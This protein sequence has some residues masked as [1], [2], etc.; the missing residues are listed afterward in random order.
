MVAIKLLNLQNEGAQKSFDREC[1]VLGRV[2]HWNL[3][4]II[5]CYSDLQIKALIFPLMSNGSLEKWLYPDDG[6]QSGLNLI[7]RL[8]IAIDIAQGMAYLHHHCFVQVI[9]CD[10][11]PNNVLLGEDITAYLIDFGI[12]TI[13]FAN[14]ED[15]DFTSTN[16]LKGSTGYIAPEYGVGGQVTTKGDVY[17]YGIMLLEMLTRKKPTNDMFAE[18]MN[19]QKWVGSLFPSRVQEV[20]DMS[21]LRRTNRCTEEDKDL[22]CLSSLINVGLL[23]TNESPQGRPTM[24][25]ILGTLQNIRDTFLSSTSIPKFQSNLTHLLGS[26]S[27]TINNICDS[28]SS[29][30]L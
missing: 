19:L 12:A 22:N 17:S 9:H 6:Q 29:S 30:T 20:V 15:G 16:A 4:Q 24:M 5:T 7:Q 23:C 27:T 2:R 25:D 11:K 28:Q 14:N 13:C 26:T 10:L 21:L 1:K 8:N 3:I 18:G